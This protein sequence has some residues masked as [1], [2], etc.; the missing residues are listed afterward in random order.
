MSHAIVPSPRPAR[1]ARSGLAAAMGLTWVVSP[2]LPVE[3]HEDAYAKRAT[4]LGVERRGDALL[5]NTPSGTTD[6][7]I[8]QR[9]T[10]IGQLEELTLVC[11]FRATST[12]AGTQTLIAEDP[13]SGGNRVFQFRINAGQ[14]Q[15]IPFR[16]GSPITTV[17]TGSLSVGTW[18]IAIGSS[19]NGF[20]SI[21]LYDGDGTFLSTATASGSG[22][23]GFDTTKHTRIGILSNDTTA[24][25][26]G[27]ISLA[28]GGGRYI[29]ASTMDALARDLSV[30]LEPEPRVPVFFSL[31]S[32]GIPTLSL[33]GVQDITAV[34]ARPR[35]TLSF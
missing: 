33:P 20:Q 32:S 29:T 34:S 4:V 18:Y 19:R 10:Q 21:R 11:R 1:I 23:L 16:G 8:R 13:G 31:P 22:T 27:E 3:F 25:F 12:V 7:I 9:M 28:A 24:P 35:V 17:I 15:F 2:R 26:T 30:L 6:R 14:V 5:F